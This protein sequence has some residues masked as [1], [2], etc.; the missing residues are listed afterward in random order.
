MVYLSNNFCSCVLPGTVLGLGCSCEH[1][2]C[3]PPPWSSQSSGVQGSSAHAGWVRDWVNGQ[4]PPGRDRV[5][6]VSTSGQWAAGLPK[7][8]RIRVLL[9]CDERGWRGAQGS[10]VQ[11]VGVSDSFHL[12]SQL[13]SNWSYPS[14]PALAP[15]ARHPSFLLSIR[16]NQ[17][18]RFCDII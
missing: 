6:S 11:P 3:V 18:A 17:A 5:S 15:V 7:V 9:S 12:S 14:S 1:Q 8:V 13:I 10:L 16:S 2:S 4:G